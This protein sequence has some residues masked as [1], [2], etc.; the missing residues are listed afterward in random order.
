MPKRTSIF[1][2]GNRIPHKR[3]KTIHSP[4]L[5]VSDELL[6]R[7][8][9]FL[10]VEVLTICQSVSRRLNLVAGDSELWKKAYHNSFV[11]PRLDRLARYKRRTKSDRTLVSSRGLNWLDENDLIR[12]GR[13]TDWQ[14]RFKTRHRWS[15]GLCDLDEIVIPHTPPTPRL[16]ARM[17]DGVVHA[18]DM[19][20]GLRAWSYRDSKDLLALT[21]RREWQKSSIKA[22]P[23]S[24]AVDRSSEDGNTHQI[25]VGSDDGSLTCN[26]YIVSDRRY[27]FV[28]TTSSLSPSP[29]T[30]VAI[31]GSYIA[32]MAGNCAL[33]LY[34]YRSDLNSSQE[35]LDDVG[36][37][38]VASLR[39]HM[40]HSTLSLSIRETSH[41][42]LV[43]LA[44]GSFTLTSGWSSGLQELRFDDRGNLLTSRLASAPTKAMHVPSRGFSGINS[45][46]NVERPPCHTSKPTSISYYHPYLLMAHADNTLTLSMVTST[47]DVLTI[48]PKTRLWGHTSSVLGADIGP[49]GRAV[50]VSNRGGEIRVWQLEEAASISASRILGIS[51]IDEGSIKLSPENVRRAEPSSVQEPCRPATASRYRVIPAAYPQEVVTR[52]WVGFDEENVVVLNEQHGSQ[53]LAV[54]A[55]S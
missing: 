49:R 3:L 36:P 41:S 31:S 11:Q 53:S 13:E 30:A 9:S 6:L 34:R 2:D 27:E 38:L 29:V 5:D 20:H 55:F 45:D 4:L 46:T 43:C 24:I 17:L 51:Q 44:Y 42:I 33:S 28:Y 21:A 48:S 22:K 7:I 39:S 19:D 14:R 35:Q 54:Y 18:A 8:L 40:V 26:K 37:N 10:P 15:R 23:I 50:S 47:T 32:T 1:E 25:V 12:Y 16:V 52:E